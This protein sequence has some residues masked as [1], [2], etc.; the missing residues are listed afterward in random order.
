[1]MAPGLRSK[2]LALLCLCLFAA[3]SV[4]VHGPLGTHEHG[5]AGSVTASAEPL[6]A[7]RLSSDDKHHEH[8]SRAQLELEVCLACRSNGDDGSLALAVAAPHRY[9][10][11][12]APRAYRTDA[13]MR[14]SSGSSPG[15]PR[16]PPGSPAT[17]G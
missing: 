2:I 14:P 15:A 4:H 17:R 1:M 16:A 10:S 13:A 12:P 7:E 11:F 5:E 8:D 9:A 3:S 6:A